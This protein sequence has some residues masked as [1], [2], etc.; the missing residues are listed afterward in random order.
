MKNSQSLAS[1]YGRLT[2][3]G[4]TSV[5]GR[6]VAKVRCSCGRTKDVLVDSLLM[7][8]TKSCGRGACKTYP[9]VE[10]DPTYHPTAPRSMTL[11]TVS[12][13]WARYNHATPSQRR[14]VA[15]LATIHKVNQNTLMSV[16]RS[17]R[18]A[19]GIKDYLKKVKQ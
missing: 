12:R 5:D 17:V 15:Q 2:V 9:R 16:F 11:T 14:T 8:R 10:F 6:R 13:A 18:R 1:T 7:G 3:L 19:G 4:E